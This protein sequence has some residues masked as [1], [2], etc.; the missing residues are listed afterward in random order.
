MMRSGDLQNLVNNVFTHAGGYFV[1]ARDKNNRTVWARIG[2]LTRD[3]VLECIYRH[4][5][6]PAPY[7]FRNRN[8]PALCIGAQRIAKYCLIAM[9][10]VGIN[11]RIFKAH[12]I[13]G[14]TATFLLSLGI[15]KSLVKS[16]G[17]WSSEECMDWYYS[18]L[19]NLIPWDKVLHTQVVPGLHE[20][21]DNRGQPLDEACPLG[22]ALGP[23]GNFGAKHRTKRICLYMRVDCPTAVLAVEFR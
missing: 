1:V 3:L 2:G 15:E 16:R 12:S 21:V 4:R 22:A 5:G 20:L 14:A 7:M 8:N 19:H 11:T 23:E 10:G 13:R 9:D 17:N 6:T 18:R